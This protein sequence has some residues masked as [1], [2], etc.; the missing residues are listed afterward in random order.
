[1]NALGEPAIK[2]SES[3]EHLPQAPIAEAVIE[4]KAR[5]TS[6]WK[7]PLVRTS[8][9]QNLAEYPIRESQNEVRFEMKVLPGKPPAQEFQDLGWKGFRVQ[10]ADKRQ[11]AQFTRDGFVFS[12]L[13]PYEN[14]QQLSNEALRLWGIFKEMARPIKIGQIGLRYINRIPLPTNGRNLEDY[15]R[16]APQP[17][18]DSGLVLRS[19]MHLD[20]LEV[21]GHPYAVRLVKTIQHVPEQ[22]RSRCYLILDIDV[23][24]QAGLDEPQ[25]RLEE[26]RWLKNSVFFSSITDK[27]REMFR[28][29]KPR[30]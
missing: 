15:V 22:G 1:M 20:E 30:L 9:E 8:L 21:P 19:F 12:R 23:L 6:D 27:A 16:P 28:G 14:W 7:E 17:P 13:P 29:E 10:T 24:A 5:A 4:I 2:T 18:Q 25:K 11:V 26:M 3:F